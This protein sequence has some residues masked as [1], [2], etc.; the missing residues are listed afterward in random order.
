MDRRLSSGLVPPRLREC[1]AHVPPAPWPPWAGMLLVQ[2]PQRDA[3]Q[4]EPRDPPQPQL[5][6]LLKPVQV[7][8]P[9]GQERQVHLPAVAPLRKPKME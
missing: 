9:R 4:K 3:L 1:S 6:E 5:C 7:R 2:H 8:G